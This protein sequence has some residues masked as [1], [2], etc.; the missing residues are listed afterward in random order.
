MVQWGYKADPDQELL[1]DSYPVWFWSDSLQG[2]S[3]LLHA[4]TA[5][6]IFFKL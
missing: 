3:A 1:F 4:Q 5:L 6:N 2:H